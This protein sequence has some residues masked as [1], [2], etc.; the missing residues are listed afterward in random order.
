MYG[1]S[2]NLLTYTHTSQI[3]RD[4]DNFNSVKN[5]YYPAFFNTFSRY[6]LTLILVY[7]PLLSDR[8]YTVSTYLTITKTIKELNN[9][10]IITTGA[11]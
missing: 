6:L 9:K 5:S 8:F 1:A 2:N 10:L 11:L 3:V 4:I 7:L